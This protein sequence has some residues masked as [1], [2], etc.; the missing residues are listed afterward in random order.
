MSNKSLRILYIHGFASRFDRASEKVIALS[1]LGDV[2]G[3]NVD[4]VLGPER[5]LAEIDKVI[6]NIDLVVGTSMGGW[7][8]AVV[9]GLY[10]LP[11][12]SI[13]PAIM[14]NKSLKKY[15]GVGETFFGQPFTLL[16]SVVDSYSPYAMAHHGL[17]LLDLADEVIDATDTMA[18]LAP[19]MHIASFPGG[20]HRFSH[21]TESIGLIANY[22]SE[23]GINNLI[24]K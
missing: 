18:K 13:N 9:G 6:K 4:Y 23:I 15:L 16:E 17:V 3:V 24:R 7:T 21:M 1:K 5:V 11:F 22:Y 19:V 10:K 14:P 2:V 20:N 8:A 12:V